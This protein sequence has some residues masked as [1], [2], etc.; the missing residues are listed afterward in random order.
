MA[1]TESLWNQLVNLLAAASDSG[2]DPGD[3]G[4]D[5]TLADDLGLSSMMVISLALDFEEQFG[6]T[7]VSEEFSKMGVMTAGA[8]IDLIEAKLNREAQ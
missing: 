2:I 1:A 8:I 7:I 3:I 6:I 5:T 4:R